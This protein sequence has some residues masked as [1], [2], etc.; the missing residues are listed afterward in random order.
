MFLRIKDSI[1]VIK[2]HPQDN[3]KITN[4]AYLDSDKPSNVILIGD[5]T[6]RGKII[7]KKFIMFDQ[8]D[9]NA[10]V[11]SSDGFLTSSSSSI[12]Q[13]IA[14]GIKAGIVDNFNNGFYDYLIPYEA[15][16]LINSEEGLRYFLENKKLK[17]SDK[18]L[19]Y[20]GLENKNKDLIWR[21]IIKMFGEFDKKKNKH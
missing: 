1:L 15:I 19:R 2:T 4:Y 8:F 10:A 16:M 11:A 20:C 13:A 3:G 21:A 14:L 6:Q 9:F 7:S 17:I 18:V 5:I 12:L